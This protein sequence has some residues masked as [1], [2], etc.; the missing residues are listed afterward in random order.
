M[1]VLSIDI[2]VLFQCSTYQ[3][4]QDEDLEPEQSWQVIKWKSEKRGY[5]NNLFEPDFDTLDFIKKV[6]QKKCTNALSYTICEHDEIYEILKELP[7][8]NNHVTN[9][10]NHHDITYG[11]DISELTI[12]NWVSHGRKDG[13]ILDYLWICRDDS[14]VC[15][16]SPFGYLRSSWK[17]VNVDA[18]PEYDVVV[19]CIS[20]HYTPPKYWDVAQLLNEYLCNIVQNDFIECDEPII[21]ISKYPEYDGEEDGKKLTASTWYKYFD[22]YVNAEL[23]EGV[24]WLSFINLGKNVNVLTPCTRLLYQL[25]QDNTIGFCWSTGY[26]SEVLIKRLAKPYDIIDQYEKGS[27]SHYILKIKKED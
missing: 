23:V 11:D 17:D 18:L 13:L 20:K 27:K 2:D 24:L 16:M 19:F 10:D 15:N 25:I 5:N 22:F 6:L 8:K 12:A 4:F 7:E 9:I 1:K 3:D 26:K 14:E 21:D